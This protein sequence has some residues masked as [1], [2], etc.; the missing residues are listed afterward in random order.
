VV[1]LGKKDPS[2]KEN[3]S[4]LIMMIRKRIINSEKAKKK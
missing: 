4:L 3:F 2:K 1:A